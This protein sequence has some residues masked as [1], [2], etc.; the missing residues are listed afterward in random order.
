MAIMKVLLDFHCMQQPVELPISAFS[1]EAAGG[2]VREGP[3]A[4]PINDQGPVQGVRVHD[5]SPLLVD[6]MHPVAT[7]SRSKGRI[8]LSLEKLPRD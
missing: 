8:W 7:A 5:C 1:N 6:I 4:E 3:K 2:A